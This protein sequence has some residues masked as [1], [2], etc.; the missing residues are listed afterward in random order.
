MKHIVT[1]HAIQTIEVDARDSI[2]AIKKAEKK[3]K[4]DW[5]LA[6]AVVIDN[7]GNKHEQSYYEDE[8]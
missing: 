3:I 5:E 6:D 7:M 2:Q 1:F 4:D 8:P